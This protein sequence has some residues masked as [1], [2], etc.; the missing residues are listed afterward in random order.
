MSLAR[1]RSLNL[2][3]KRMRVCFVCNEYPPVPHGGIGSSTQNLARALVEAGHS[4][5]VIGIYPS[6]Y[7]RNNYEV[8]QGVHVWR[9]CR[10]GFRGGWTFDRIS[11]YRMVRSWA[12][13]GEIDVIDVP[14]WEGLAAGWRRLPVPVVARL[15][16]SQ[17]YFAAELATPLKKTMYYLEWAS[18][19]RAD[20][21]C[22]KS[23]YTAVKTQSL[24]GLRT[25]P[26]AILYN[27][28][29][30]HLDIHG[31]QRSR[32]QVVFTGTL[33][34]K[35][36]VFSLIRAW[37]RVREVCRDAELHL[38]GKDGRMSNGESVTAC[39]KTQL[40]KQSGDVHFHGHVA[41][42]TLNR[43]LSQAAVAVF[44]SYAEAFANAPLEAMACGCPTIY[45]LHGSGPELI[46]HGE[47][48]LL[49]DP[50]EP[51]Q[52]ADAIIQLL[53]D[54]RLAN[55][56][57]KAGRKHVNTE[58]STEKMLERNLAVYSSC[59]NDFHKMAT[60]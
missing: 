4:V 60:I 46:T 59:T 25:D 32:N 14:D 28:V 30:R 33:V 8:D 36:G 34:A 48:G 31:H 41:R 23:Q 55:T 51:S 12:T 2:H 49:I 21:W 53:T 44:P 26:R 24:F 22:S 10:R 39:L 58:F 35:K 40:G 19:R 18:L 29:G 9:L 47:T 13:R 52:I 45:S 54:A 27:P 42:T 15:C 6:A 11:L 56:L 50:N 16:G 3:G 37:P 5:R 1:D 20:Y 38:F 17:T 7:A 57:G 43:V